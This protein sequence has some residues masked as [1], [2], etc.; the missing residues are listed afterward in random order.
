MKALLIDFVETLA[1]R[2]PRREQVLSVLLKDLTGIEVPLTR[3]R[4]VY[5][6]L[7]EMLPFSSITMRATDT[8]RQHYRN[9]N[10]QLLGLLGMP[11]SHAQSV[12]EA[13]VGYRRQ[14]RLKDGATQLLEQLAARAI[15]V[16]IVSNFDAGLSQIVHSDL[17][18]PETQIRAILA[19]QEIGLEKPDPA[20]FLAAL[21]RLGVNPESATHVGD[22]VRLDYLPARAL[23]MGAILLDDTDDY[24][25]LPDSVA[26]LKQLCERLELSQ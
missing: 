24:A 3:L 7:D 6:T 17:C 26:G 4:S 19:S 23:G 21:Q 18:V 11:A 14:W 5:R 2:W 8:K 15:P 25:H 13:F 9:Y 10:T 16:A 1:E 22:S 20:F 12:Y